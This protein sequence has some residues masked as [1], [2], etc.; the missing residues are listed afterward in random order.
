MGTLRWEKERSV[1]VAQE[2]AEVARKLK[3]TTLEAEEALLEVQL[4]AVQIDLA[5]KR[6]EKE[7]LTRLAV[8]LTEEQARANT[9]LDELRGV[10]EK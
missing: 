9:H 2:E 4:K 1:R 3:Q 8:D 6:A 10:D 5:A 7:V